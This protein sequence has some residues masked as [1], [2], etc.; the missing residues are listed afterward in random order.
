MLGGIEFVSKLQWIASSNCFPDLEQH[1]MCAGDSEVLTKRNLVKVE[2]CIRKRKVA[3]TKGTFHMQIHHQ[4]Y[5]SSHHITSQASHCALA[6]HSQR[7][8]IQHALFYR[9][10]DFD[11]STDT[12]QYSRSP[13]FS[14][15]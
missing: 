8:M 9:S 2:Y 7:S 12:H 4:N 5:D 3:M 13:A 1:K 14:V 11:C 15:N 6:D 10:I